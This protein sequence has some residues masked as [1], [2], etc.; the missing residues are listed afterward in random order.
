MSLAIFTLD[1]DDEIELEHDDV[2]ENENS[3]IEMDMAIEFDFDNG[4]I[5]TNKSHES[6]SSRVIKKRIEGEIVDKPMDPEI[7]PGEE[8]TNL[9]IL[10]LDFKN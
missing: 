10:N 2:D 5:Y 7:L 1:S 9:R 6:R 3:N 8:E 4:D